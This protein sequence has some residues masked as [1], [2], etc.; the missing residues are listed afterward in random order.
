MPKRT[1]Q[2]IAS[3]YP[4]VLEQVKERA[5]EQSRH[6]Q[7]TKL[8]AAVQ[9]AN[10]WETFTL[11][12]R[13]VV[14]AAGEIPSTLE[15]ELESRVP[16][17]LKTIEPNLPVILKA[18]A[19]G[20]ELWNLAYDWGVLNIFGESYRDGWLDAVHYFSSMSLP[21]MKAWAHW[22][23]INKEWRTNLPAEWPAYEQWQTEVCA[24]T[25]LSNPE[26]VAQQVLDTVNS[27][28]EGQWE[29]LLS[30]FLD[31]VAFSLWME[32]ILDVDG[33]GCRLLADELTTRYPGF[34]FSRPG[35]SSAEAVR[36]LNSWAVQ[37]TLHADESILAA[38]SWHIRNNPAYY[39]LRNYAAECHA[40]WSDH[41]TG[42]LP[43]FDEWRKA[44]DDYVSR[45]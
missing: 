6:V 45:I 13:A 2:G 35:L 40:C 5:F 41:H 23:R 27:L 28:P 3:Q 11:W 19:P 38:L 37:N 25:R 12:L 43:S 42:R 26:S 7:W 31:L 29:R 1:N 16:D 33:R 21:Y 15:H 9:E 10:E 22:E 17:F 8:A 32:L 44:A 24:V 34:A 4:G 39:A 30:S 14:D 36:D 18:D 20:H